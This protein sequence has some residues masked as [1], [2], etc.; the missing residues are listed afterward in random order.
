MT[1]TLQTTRGGKVI[2]RLSLHDLVDAVDSGDR[3]RAYCPI[4][5][6]DHQRSLSIER[7][8]GWGY[9]HCCHATV[10]VETHDPLIVGGGGN[11]YRRRGTGGDTLSPP[12]SVV[13]LPPSSLRPDAVRQGRA[14]TPL[15]GWQHGEVAALR[16]V[17]PL[18]HASL[19]ASQRGQGYLNERGIPPTI[20][21]AA[22]IGYL[23]R[24]AWEQAPVSAEQRSLLKRWIGRIIFP[25]GSL[26]GGGFIGRTLLRWEPG[27]NENAHKVVLDQP[28]APRR[29]IKTNPAGWFGFEAPELLAEW[30]ILVEGGFDRLALLA[31]GFPAMNVIAL[32]GTAARP[33]WLVRSAPQVKGVVLALDADEGGKNAMERL[34]IEFKQAG[35]TVAL[36]PPLHDPWGKDWNERWRRLG[37]QSMWPLYEAVATH[38][39]ALNERK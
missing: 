24:C 29:W 7:A 32:V 27:M 33:A 20:A 22:H 17:T 5:G 35:L 34:A 12:P 21:S 38:A 14:A 10:L 3:L 2:H 39:T 6:G 30:V 15:P 26:Y 28:G 8:T 9:C 36:C 16:A 11:T 1:I 19:A 13:L 4:H 23:S 25:L 37:P 31:A 18:M